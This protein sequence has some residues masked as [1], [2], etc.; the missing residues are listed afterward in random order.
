MMHAYW[1]RHAYMPM[2]HTCPCHAYMPM[3]IASILIQHVTPSL[4]QTQQVIMTMCSHCASA[5][6]WWRGGCRRI[7][8]SPQSGS[9]W[10]RRPK[11]PHI[12]WGR[13]YR[14]QGP[15]PE[16]AGESNSIPVKKFGMGGNAWDYFGRHTRAASTLVGIRACITIKGPAPARTN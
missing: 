11:H 9:L 3:Y 15:C 14:S 8:S 13:C 1:I 6:W 4:T 7:G 16:R 5:R 10:R 2:F 12:R